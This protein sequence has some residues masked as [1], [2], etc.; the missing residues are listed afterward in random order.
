V[1]LP[2]CIFSCVALFSALVF[3]IVC[4]YK[5]GKYQGWREVLRQYAQYEKADLTLDEGETLTGVIELRKGTYFFLGINTRRN[6]S[7]E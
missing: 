1:N 3:A 2:V 4:A 7:W 6:S 5:L